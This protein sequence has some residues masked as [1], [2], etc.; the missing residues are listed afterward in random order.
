MWL[1]VLVGVLFLPF[2]LPN[3]MKKLTAHGLLTFYYFRYLLSALSAF[4]LLASAL[5]MDKVETNNPDC[6]HQ[7]Q[8][9]CKINMGLFNGLKSVERISLF[10]FF[11]YGKDSI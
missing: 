1:L 10:I 11:S 7:S 2:F 8:L 4:F 3:L 5:N 9:I 6:K